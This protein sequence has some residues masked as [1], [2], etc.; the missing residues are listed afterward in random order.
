M[1]ISEALDITFALNKLFLSYPLL[2]CFSS[3]NDSPDRHSR[4]DMVVGFQTSYARDH[5]VRDH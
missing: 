5:R 4:D 2:F 3:Y 1:T